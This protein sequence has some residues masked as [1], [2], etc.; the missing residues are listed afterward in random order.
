MTRVLA[1]AIAPSSVS[2]RRNRRFTLAYAATDSATATLDVL[3]RKKKRVGGTRG[4]T[5]AGRNTIAA[6]VTTPGSYTLR[7]TLTKGRLKTTDS[8][9]LRVR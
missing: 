5:K 8:V 6:T 1:V 3:D 7:L 2:A 4:S 9:P